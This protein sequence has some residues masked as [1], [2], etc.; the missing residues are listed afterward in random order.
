MS[1]ALT[2]PGVATRA[3]QLILYCPATTDMALGVVIPEITSGLEIVLVLSSTL[4]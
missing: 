3:H 2:V 1:P 4:F